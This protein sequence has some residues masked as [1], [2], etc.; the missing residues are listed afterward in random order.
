MIPK[1]IHYCWF[2]RKPL[3][4]LSKKCIESWQK[5]LPDYEIREWNESNF[6]V[7]IIQYTQEAYGMKKYAFVSD[8]ARFHILNKYGGLYFDIDVEVISSFENIVKTGS[9][10]GFQKGKGWDNIGGVAPGLGMG[11]IPKHPFIRTLLER[12]KSL[13]FINNDGSLNLKTVVA[14]TTENFLDRGLRTEDVIQNIAGF[15]L[16]PTDYFCP[17][18]FGSDEC[19]ITK[20]TLSI[21]HYASSWLPWYYRLEHKCCKKLK[22]QNTH[23]LTNIIKKGQSIWKR[24]GNKL[25]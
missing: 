4:E 25:H 8:Y 9:F 1:I 18:A 23:R 14:Y 3:P 11:C 17:I 6:D 21:H 20:N 13:S 16:Y 10:M 5:Y 15:T 2:G 7:N 22:I 19:A 12:Y 24:L